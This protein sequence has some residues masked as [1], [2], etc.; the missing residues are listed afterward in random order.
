MHSELLV[1]LRSGIF[2]GTAI[3][4]FK[5]Y[6]YVEDHR[7]GRWRR[8]LRCDPSNSLALGGCRTPDRCPVRHYGD[9]NPC[10]ESDRPEQKPLREWAIEIINAHSTVKMGADA[11]KELLEESLS[12]HFIVD[13]TNF[14]II[15]PNA[16]I[17]PQG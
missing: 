8:G 4:Y 12:L 3:I 14:E 15:T 10:R 2:R 16:T 9:W 6:R 17:R 7:W 1:D 11:Q 5:R 13:G